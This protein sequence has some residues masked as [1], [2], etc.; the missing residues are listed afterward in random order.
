MKYR[1]LRRP[2][3]VLV[4]YPAQGHVTPMVQ[5]A[6]ALR[7]QGFDPV[8]VIPDFIHRRILSSSRLQ[9][10]QD[11]HGIVFMSIPSGLDKNEPLNFFTIGFAMES[12]MPL[13][14]EHIIC[15]LSN[16]S[17]KEDG[18]VACV[19]VDLVASWAIEV[20]NRCGVHVAGF[21][22]AMLATYHLITSIPD[23]IKVGLIDDF[24][25]PQHQGTGCFMPSQTLL[26]TA[27]LPWLVG[28]SASQ[29]SRFSFWIRILD[30]LRALRW[31]LVNSFPEGYDSQKHK[32]HL[33]KGTQDYPH[34]FLIGPLTRHSGNKNLSF[35]EEDRSCLNWL[36]EQKT[37][38]VIYVSFGSWVGPIGE[39]KINELALGLE[40][41]R[42]PFI[43][44]V[45][46]TWRK[47]L[48]MGYLERIAKQGSK[49]VSWAPQKELLQHEAIGC[50]LTH[51]GWN[52]TME[53]IQCGRR[54]L[55]YPVSGD[56]FVNC[57]YIVKVWGIGVE[58][59]GDG[60]RDVED[61][62]RRVMEEGEEMQQ[63]IL[64][65]KERVLGEKGS[66]GAAATLTAFV[67]DL[68]RSII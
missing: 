59:H 24:G 45:A 6:L 36:H 51:C 66:S 13:H 57:K 34:I 46:P 12:N 61:G 17:D 9:Q 21:W 26:T 32:Y 22:P 10:L 55:C 67:D 47:G 38:S 15:R 43:W 7:C 52:S 65:W 63:R 30:R 5:M 39:E 44:V 50:Y 3:V 62:V 27:D 58:M 42:R 40:A 31:L 20:A 4:P 49:L 41:T 18:V 23:M 2:K 35:W 25:I 53:A 19:I 54:L 33:I 68:K 56:Q 28:N 37:G 8:I 64:E 60:R 1:A 29:K 11:D 14:L 48:P 16:G